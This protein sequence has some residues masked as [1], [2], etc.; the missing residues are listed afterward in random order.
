MELS[1]DLIEILV[2][3]ES[4]Q[5]LVYFPNGASD[6]QDAFLYCPTS[7]LRYSVKDGIPIMLIEEA[8]RLDEQKGAQLLAQAPAPVT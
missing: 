1:Q 2:C 3:P 4:K 5:P 7:R 8:E 6:K